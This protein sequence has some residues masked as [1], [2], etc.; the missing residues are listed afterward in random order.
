MPPTHMLKWSE[1]FQNVET[2]WVELAQ[3]RQVAIKGK[4]KRN[5]YTVRIR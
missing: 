5:I 1:Q 2:P 3:Q 4:K